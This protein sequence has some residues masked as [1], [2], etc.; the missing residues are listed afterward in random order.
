MFKSIIGKKITTLF[1]AATIAF[2]PLS[3]HAEGLKKPKYVYIKCS[4][5]GNCLSSQAL[6]QMGYSVRGDLFVSTVDLG[7]YTK[8][9]WRTG[10]GPEDAALIRIENFGG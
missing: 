10:N 1:L 2:L 4:V 3:A 8:I 7:V 5:G 6:A 9:N